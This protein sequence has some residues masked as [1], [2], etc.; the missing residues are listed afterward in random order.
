MTPL[1]ERLEEAELLF[2]ARGDTATAELFTE[3][4]AALHKFRGQLEEAV[5]L[6]NDYN[7]R[8]IAAR[9]VIAEARRLN[10]ESRRFLEDLP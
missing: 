2:T 4:M 10:A 7:L 6:M 1:I 5:E 9:E 8:I 3:A